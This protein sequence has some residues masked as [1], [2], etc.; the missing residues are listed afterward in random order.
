MGKIQVVI[1][2]HTFRKSHILRTGI[3]K[4]SRCSS[5]E[6]E[7]IF[8]I[9]FS[10]NSYIVSGNLMRIS[11]ITAG[12][13]LTDNRYNDLIFKLRNCLITI[14][15]GKC[16]VFEVR[17]RIC[18]SPLVQSHIGRTCI[19]T[20]CGLRSGIGKIILRI[21]RIVTCEL[22]TGYT[23]LCLV[24]R[25][26]IRL[27]DNGNRSG[28]LC[29]LKGCCIRNFRCNIIVSY[30]NAYLLIAYIRFRRCFGRPIGPGF[31]VRILNAVFG[32]CGNSVI[33]DNT[34]GVACLVIST[35]ISVHCS[36]LGNQTVYSRIS[37][38]IVRRNFRKLI[39]N[40]ICI[41][42]VRPSVKDIIVKII[43][44]TLRS[45]GIIMGNRSTDY[46]RISLEKGI[47]VVFPFNRSLMSGFMQGCLIIT[48]IRCGFV[49]YTVPVGVILSA[50]PAVR[51]SEPGIIMVQFLL[52]GNFHNL[53][54]IIR[55]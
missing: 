33:K 25:F 45:S 13:I 1:P 27:S 44:R 29:N 2:E 31:A 22:I 20:G 53:N 14:R 43:R 28:S 38:G 42:T 30:A 36:I 23:V 48:M 51:I 19:R 10:G 47:V 11:V 18:K 41:G 9:E 12:I 21:Y 4:R 8:G 54:G 15:N 3:L 39:I 49:R 55:Q 34:D 5:G 6:T 50:D 17:V 7:I 52:N 35:G 37:D 32:S 16:N 26:N 46:I 40:T 24:V